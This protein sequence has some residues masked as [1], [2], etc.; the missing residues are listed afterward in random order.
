MTVITSWIWKSGADVN[1]LKL[2]LENNRLEWFDAVG[3]ACGDSTLSQTFG[4][5]AERGPAF[6]GVPDDI[7]AEIL[8]SLR[9]LR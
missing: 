3:C 1:A 5:F 8:V 2:D 7:M 9:A 4:D 6:S